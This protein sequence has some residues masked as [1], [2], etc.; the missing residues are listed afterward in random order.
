MGKLRPSGGN[1][2]VRHQAVGCQLC[3][4][5]WRCPGTEMS[6]CLGR[7]W[8]EGPCL[9]WSRAWRLGGTQPQGPSQVRVVEGWGQCG[10]FLRARAGGGLGSWGL[11]LPP[12]LSDERLPC[13]QQWAHPSSPGASG[14]QATQQQHEPRQG[15][16]GPLSGEPRRE[17]LGGGELWGLPFPLTH[18]LGACLFGS[19]APLQASLATGLVLACSDS[20]GSCG[21][22]Q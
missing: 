6:A 14:L 12:L 4:S 17:G 15:D 8:A 5:S 18:S 3:L 11:W 20:G 9:N 7:N 13:S 2:P 16:R 10:G 22:G 1:E 21:Q 19:S